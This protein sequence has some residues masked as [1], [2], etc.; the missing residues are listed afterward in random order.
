M[1][2]FEMRA[3]IRSI[4]SPAP[5]RQALPWSRTSG[6][7]WEVFRRDRRLALDNLARL[8][9]SQ[10]AAES[11]AL[12]VV[13]DEDPR[14]IELEASFSDKAGSERETVKVE[15]KS[16]PKGGLTGHAAAHGE[17]LRLNHAEI[18]GNEYRAKLTSDHLKSAK[19]F[20]LLT[21]PVYDRH[22]RLLGLIKLE[23]K[24]GP[25]GVP[26]ESFE[27]SKQDQVA[28]GHVARELV[29]AIAQV[30]ASK[31]IR[32]VIEKVMSAAPLD[33]VLA[34][35]LKRV[36]NV[37]R[38][39]RADLA[40]I[41]ESAASSLRVV[42][43]LGSGNIAVGKPVPEKSVVHGVWATGKSALRNNVRSDPDY[44]ACDFSTESEIAA[45]I[46]W[47]HKRLGVINVE[48][49]Q[50]GWFDQ[51]DLE[52][53]EAFAECAAGACWTRVG[54]ERQRPAEQAEAQFSPV[55]S[56]LE[57]LLKVLQEA[58][59]LDGGIVYVA[60]YKKQI[61]RC[62]AF[63]SGSRDSVTLN[64]PREFS[65]A[66]SEVSLATRV[67]LSGT[68]RFIRDPFSSSDVNVAGLKAFQ[69]AGP[70][71]GIP[72]HFQGTV[73]GV[74]VQWSGDPERQP[75]EESIGALE[76]FA[77]V[78]AAA[79]VMGAP[80]LGLASAAQERERAAATNT[81]ER[82]EQGRL[83][84]AWAILTGTILGCALGSLTRVP[85]IV[86][87]V[88]CGGAVAAFLWWRV[89]RARVLSAYSGTSAPSS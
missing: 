34:F 7:V 11:S 9:H 77:S 44:F 71:V 42:Q 18:R 6:R 47:E 25:G 64:N 55:R 80:E 2:G 61:L 12:F 56:F 60:D 20:S 78:A 79:I 37:L 85:V 89:E 24:K 17:P 67:F 59:G 41:D 83:I 32:E 27:F 29:D 3:R 74:L 36:A 53:V 38:C 68:P 1:T 63:I 26:G 73:V 14:F 48:A 69:I 8:L 72:L 70:L 57:Q 10:L 54:R 16:Q 51:Q 46:D 75:T 23:N 66:F 76:P 28:A 35:L 13:S 39:E 30:R 62:E 31:A 45:R 84:P 43:Q 33:E 52:L 4:F 5:T 65:Y 22:R 50:V 87:F 58:H 19:C 88:V 82:L 15:I 49:S 21:V 81:I 40:L 86:W